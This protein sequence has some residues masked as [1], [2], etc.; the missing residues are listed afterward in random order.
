MAPGM[1]VPS[2]KIK[3]GV[4]VADMEP[5]YFVLGV[6][7]FNLPNY[8]EAYKRFTEYVQKYPTGPKVHQVNLD[9]VPAQ[10]R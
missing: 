7:M 3:V 5:L 9:L 1:R 6:C 2:M 4:P 10:D 8:D